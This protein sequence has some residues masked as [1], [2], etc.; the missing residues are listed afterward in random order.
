VG[1]KNKKKKEPEY[2]GMTGVKK[3]RDREAVD[4]LIAILEE[5]AGPNAVPN[6]TRKIEVYGS[7]DRV[8]LGDGSKAD[9]YRIAEISYSVSGGHSGVLSSGSSFMVCHPP[10]LG[11]IKAC[12][13]YLE[14]FHEEAYRPE[15]WTSDIDEKA[16]AEWRLREVWKEGL[17]P[18]DGC[19]IQDEGHDVDAGSLKLVKLGGPNCGDDPPGPAGGV[20]GG[21]GGQEAGGEDLRPG[22]G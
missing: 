18:P 9:L 21:G 1:K 19:T 10:C 14:R 8:V 15:G 12:E 20:P 13:Q 6:T 3:K 22:A 17:G 4:G 2:R 11:L 16:D 5:L 7:Y